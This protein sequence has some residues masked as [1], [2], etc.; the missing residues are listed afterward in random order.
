M[1]VDI[2]PGSGAVAITV[3]AHCPQADVHARRHQ[4]RRARRGARQRDPQHGVTL[5]FHHGDLLAPIHDAGLQVDVLL[6]NLPY[7]DSGCCRRWTSAAMNRRWR[8]MAVGRVG[9]GAPVT[10]TSA[11]RAGAG[12]ARAAGDR[13]RSGSGRGDLARAALPDAQVDVVK[14][15]AGLD[16]IVRAVRVPRTG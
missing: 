7:I 14:D 13:R 5:T 3:A 8:S 9:R 1:I 12:R 4:R 2:G 10:G 16:R 6:A 11:T 15:L